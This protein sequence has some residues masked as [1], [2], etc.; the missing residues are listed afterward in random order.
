V[1]SSLICVYTQERTTPVPTASPPTAVCEL[2]CTVYELLSAAASIKAQAAQLCVSLSV[3]V[4]ELE[5]GC[6]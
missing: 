5:R 3:A 6:L 2:E 4:C 1:C